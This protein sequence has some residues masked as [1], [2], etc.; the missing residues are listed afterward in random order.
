MADSPVV[1]RDNCLELELSPSIGGAIS[2]F[3]FAAA[4]RRTPILRKS[5]TPLENVL[6]AACF[7]LVP[8][9]NRIRGGCFDFRGRQVRL[10]P[11]MTGDPSPLHGQGWTNAWR[12]ESRTETEA[13]L[14]FEH[15]AREWPWEYRAEQR[16]RLAGDALELSLICRNLSDERMPCG[17][18]FHP[19]F[20]CG[21]ETRIQTGVDEVWA[22]DELVL[23]TGKEPATGRYSI[24]DDPVCGRGLDNGY[25]GWCGRALLT[26]PAWPFELLLSSAR[27]RFFQLYSPQQGGIFVAEPVT[28]ANA[29]LNEPESDWAALGIEVLQPGEAMTLDARLEVQPKAAAFG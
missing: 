25:G 22:V 7:P 4:D 29:A 9:V 12:T 17:L 23:P 1:L 10:T 27:A 6:D 16:F 15:P 20:H 18:G 24:A 14:S 8:Y 2:N 28:H 13:V 21:D 19:Y 26:D 11:N 3:T 5:H